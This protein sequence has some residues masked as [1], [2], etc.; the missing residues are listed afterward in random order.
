MQIELF[1]DGKRIFTDT[2][3]GK[4]ASL[5]DK[6]YANDEKRHYKGFR[7][8]LGLRE[9]NCLPPPWFSLMKVLFIMSPSSVIPRWLSLSQHSVSLILL[10]SCQDQDKRIISNIET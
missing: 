6:N 2:V 10:L 4:V 7:L 1:I 5:Y 8:G 9:C 3:N